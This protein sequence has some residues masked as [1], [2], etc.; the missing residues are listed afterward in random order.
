[1]VMMVWPGG[2][3][4]LEPMIE[5]QELPGPDGRVSGENFRKAY[6]MR[7]ETLVKWLVETL[8]V[9]FFMQNF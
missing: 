8:R 9:E 5:F 4:C 1:M 6:C 2:W 3:F 7:L